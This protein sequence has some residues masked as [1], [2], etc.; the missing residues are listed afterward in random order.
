MTGLDRPTS[1]TPLVC[2]PLRTLLALGTQIEPIL[3]QRA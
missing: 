3:K 2:H 1:D